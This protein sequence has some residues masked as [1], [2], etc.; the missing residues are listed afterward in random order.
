MLGCIPRSLHTLDPIFPTFFVDFTVMSL[1][2]L[3]V[4]ASFEWV[5]LVVQASGVLCLMDIAA[6]M[7]HLHCLGVLHVRQL[8]PSHLSTISLNSVLHPVFLDGVLEV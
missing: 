6:G 4:R 5:R 8:P 2:S 7:S 3:I 1:E